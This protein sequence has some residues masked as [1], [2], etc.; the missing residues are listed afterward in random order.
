MMCLR[1]SSDLSTPVPEVATPMLTMHGIAHARTHT[2]TGENL[3][4]SCNDNRYY[5]S[6]AGW[7]AGNSAPWTCSSTGA[8]PAEDNIAGYTVNPNSAF[9]GKYTTSWKNYNIQSVCNPNGWLR[10]R[11]SYAVSYT[12]VFI[13]SVR[14]HFNPGSTGRSSLTS[15]EI[16][17]GSSSSIS[18]SYASTPCATISNSVISTIVQAGSHEYL[19]IECEAQGDFVWIVQPEAKCMEVLELEVIGRKSACT[20]CREGEYQDVTG[21]TNCKSCSWS[22]QLVHGTTS[23]EASRT[24]TDC[25]CKAG[26]TGN[27]FGMTQD[28]PSFRPVHMSTHGRLGQGGIRFDRGALQF[29]HSR[30]RTWHIASNGGLTIA[31]EVM[32]SGTVGMNERVVDFGSTLERYHDSFLLSRWQDSDRLYAAITEQ[33]WIASLPFC[34]LLCAHT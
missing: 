32:F 3:A 8:C 24:L 33:V 23:A 28:T 31:S 10:V 26:S 1:L 29:L 15:A 9:D 5:F 34:C 11:L 25:V 18:V 14:V 6:W 12:T 27:G 17:V 7:L 2:I 19:D 13:R 22:W 4:R 21:S 20:N 16:R 30:E